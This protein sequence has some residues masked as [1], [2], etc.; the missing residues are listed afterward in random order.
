MKKMAVWAVLGTSLMGLGGFS[1][2]G[3]PMPM[4]N[5]CPAVG[6][7]TGCAVLI[8]IGTGKALSF[9]TDSSQPSFNSSEADTLVG[10]MN[11]SDAL[12]YSI[13][14]SGKNIFG[15]DFNGACMGSYTPGPSRCPDLFNAPTSYEGYDTKGN[16]DSFTVTSLNGG[17]VYFANGLTPGDTAFFSLEGAPGDINTTPTGTTPE[18]ASVLLMVTGLAG[19]ALASKKWRFKQQQ[20]N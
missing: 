20:S 7:D 5:E 3:S 17:I 9:Q 1:A 4:F 18:P 11:N 6:Q 13:P 2:L 10:V 16:F 19:L 8:T 14:I 12:Q 15:F